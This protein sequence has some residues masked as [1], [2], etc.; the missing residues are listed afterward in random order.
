[1]LYN[2]VIPLHIKLYFIYFAIQLLTFLTTILCYHFTIKGVKFNFKIIKIA[3]LV[4]LILMIILSFMIASM[5]YNWIILCPP[6]NLSLDG[7]VYGYLILVG[8]VRKP[9]YVEEARRV[10][11]FRQMEMSDELSRMYRDLLEVYKVKHPHNPE[12]VLR[13]CLLYTSPSPRDRG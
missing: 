4:K 12:G 11:V 7:M 10:N 2:P 13:Y 9:E 8:I 6:F 3:L 5:N 1:M